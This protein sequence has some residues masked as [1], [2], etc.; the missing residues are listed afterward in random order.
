MK[1]PCCSMKGGGCALLG[2][3][4]A[5]GHC[6]GSRPGCLLMASVS[7]GCAAGEMPRE[8]T[9]FVLLGRATKLRRIKS[10]CP[11]DG[12]EK[13][14]LDGTGKEQSWHHPGRAA[15]VLGVL[16]SYERG[17]RKISC[18]FKMLTET[19]TGFSVCFIVALAL[20]LLEECGNR[21]GICRKFDL[22]RHLFQ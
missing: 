21:H 16:L 7:P 12:V 10:R 5:G 22:T 15:V 1:A 11:S 19:S 17:S 8:H 14:P 13:C 20:Q 18:T 2:Q 4:K 9:R 3:G 6:G